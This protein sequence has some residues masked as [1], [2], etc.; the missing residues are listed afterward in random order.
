MVRYERDIFS[1]EVVF[2]QV[3]NGSLP[4]RFPTGLRLET[5]TFTAGYESLL[6]KPRLVRLVWKRRN[7]FSRSV[8]RSLTFHLSRIPSYRPASYLIYSKSVVNPF[9]AP[10]AWWCN[11]SD[12]TSS[13]VFPPSTQFALSWQ[14]PNRTFTQEERKDNCTHLGHP[15]LHRA[16]VCQSRVRS[17]YLVGESIVFLSTF[18]KKD[19]TTLLQIQ[20]P[21]S[22][23]SLLAAR[24]RAYG[25]IRTSIYDWLP[26]LCPNVCPC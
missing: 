17:V 13:A 16:D 2:A 10:R 18:L 8:T 4:P 12:P 25:K 5:S 19:Q 3:L 7:L 22:W 24:E 6:S 9:S 15:M 11:S 1:F 14:S 20:S 26:Y 23:N 21:T